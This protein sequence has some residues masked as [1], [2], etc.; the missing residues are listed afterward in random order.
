MESVD[1]TKSFVPKSTSSSS[2][3]DD[4]FNQKAWI[5]TNPKDVTL[6]PGYIYDLNNL[7]LY[8]TESLRNRA[9]SLVN[10]KYIVKYLGMHESASY[11]FIPRKDLILYRGD[12]DPLFNQKQVKRFAKQYLDGLKLIR[13]SSG[14]DPVDFYVSNLY[15]KTIVLKPKQVE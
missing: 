11:G 15:F 5:R 9:I 7:P 2:D 10:K 1:A 8:I 3:W 6:W 4:Y 13:Q 14:W 12:D